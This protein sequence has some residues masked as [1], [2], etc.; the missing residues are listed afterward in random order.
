MRG[1][2]G[3]LSTP[4]AFWPSRKLSVNIKTI[5]TKKNIAAS[6]SVM[7]KKIEEKSQQ[8]EYDT[9]PYIQGL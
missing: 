3:T 1:L 8:V 2:E 5:T 6:K 7:L 4:V 9:S